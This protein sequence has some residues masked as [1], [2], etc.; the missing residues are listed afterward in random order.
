MRKSKGRE[1]ESNAFARST[2]AARRGRRAAF[3]RVLQITSDPI[4]RAGDPCATSGAPTHTKHIRYFP[5]S[6][7]ILS[8]LLWLAAARGDA[9]RTLPLS[10]KQ[11]DSDVTRNIHMMLPEDSFA[12][13]E[14]TRK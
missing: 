8:T 12:G 13:G 1:I 5:L 10:Q 7:V 2:K 3:S 14:M 6:T 4:A 11:Y 9:C